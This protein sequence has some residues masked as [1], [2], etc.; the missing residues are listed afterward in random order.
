[1]L[2]YYCA[3]IT[4]IGLIITDFESLADRLIPKDVEQL[5]PVYPNSFQPDA[6]VPQSDLGQRQETSR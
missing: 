4:P 1:M 2:D 3:L 6:K 5:R